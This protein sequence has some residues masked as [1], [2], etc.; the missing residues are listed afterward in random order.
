MKKKGDFLSY[1]ICTSVLIF[2]LG[3]FPSWGLAKDKEYPSRE[4]SIYVGAPPGGSLDISGRV[5]AKILTKPLGQPVI[6]VNKPGGT[7]TISFSYVANSK[8]DGYSLG[9]ILN[10]YLIMKKLEEPTLPFDAEKFTW[11]GS[12]YKFNFMLTVKADSP[13]KTY[14]EFVNYARKNPE[15]M[16]IG[17]DGAG[18]SQHIAQVQFSEMAGFKFKHV[19]FAG[20]GPAVQALL[21]GHVNAVTTSPGPT[22]AYLKSGDLRYLVSFSDKRNPEYPDVPTIKEKGINLFAGG[23]MAF[24]GPKGLPSEIAEKLIKLLKEAA[25]ADEARAMFKTMGWEYEYRG[26]QD[27]LK[28][29]KNEEAMFAKEMKKL[30]MIK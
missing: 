12:M 1:A 15:K 11:L 16:I 9:Y 23:W 4:V 14:E 6:V 7:Q 18:G 26:P 5:I 22:A 24:A 10:P 2:A 17:S 8:P 3:L 13:W 21:G 19:P 29:W 30:G 27:C 20:G 25:A 28:M